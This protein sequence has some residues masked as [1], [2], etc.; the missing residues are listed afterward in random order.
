MGTANR[1]TRDGCRMVSL[2]SR[3]RLLVIRGGYQHTAI[4]RGTFRASSGCCRRSNS[5]SKRKGCHRR[6]SIN[7]PKHD[8]IKS[9]TKT[10]HQRVRAS[11]K[12]FHSSFNPRFESSL[13]FHLHQLPKKRIRTEDV[14]EPEQKIM[15]RWSHAKRLQQPLPAE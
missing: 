1:K 15:G 13:L 10:V 7:Q 5:I 14:D 8:G 2:S 3:V 4:V 11:S 6:F 12:T 9:R